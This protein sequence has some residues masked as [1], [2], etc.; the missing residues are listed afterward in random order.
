[1]AMIAEAVI[2]LPYKQLHFDSFD[3]FRRH[4]ANNGLA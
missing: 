1:M 4:T 2:F 3:D